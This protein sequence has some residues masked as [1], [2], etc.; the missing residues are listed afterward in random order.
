MGIVLQKKNFLAMAIKGFEDGMDGDNESTENYANNLTVRV[1]LLQRISN[2]LGVAMHDTEDRIETI[3]RNMAGMSEGCQIIK[4][5]ILTNCNVT[6]SW[7]FGLKSTSGGLSTASEQEE[8]QVNSIA[9][10]TFEN[11]WLPHLEH[12]IKILLGCNSCP[13][14]NYPVELILVSR[15]SG[16]SPNPKEE[17]E[18]QKIITEADKI[19]VETGAMS[20]NEMRLRLSGRTFDYNIPL[21]GKAIEAEVA[22]PE[23]V[24]IQ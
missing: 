17:A 23:P 13:V 19:R 4:E 21:E 2:L 22:K 16:Y 5:E 14:K 1:N 12:I 11:R 6:E 7:L 15:K 3:D 18:T 10:K 8:K 20:G 24:V 9:N